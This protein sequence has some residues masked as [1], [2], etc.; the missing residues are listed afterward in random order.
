MLLSHTFA[1]ARSEGWAPLLLRA[2]HPQTS[3]FQALEC[4]RADPSAARKRY[5]RCMAI[6]RSLPQDGVSRSEMNRKTTNLWQWDTAT[7]ERLGQFLLEQLDD[8]RMAGSSGE[9]SVA[10]NQWSPELFGK[11]NVGRV[12]G[13]KIVP[14]LP[15]PGQQHEMG[16]ACKPEVQ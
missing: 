6:W 10:R 11:P 15:N 2:T 3:S 8:R 13:G 1:R 5:V 9:P 16:I 12:I 14:E 4:S 7:Q